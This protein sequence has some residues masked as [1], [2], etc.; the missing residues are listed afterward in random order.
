MDLSCRVEQLTLYARISP[1]K[2]TSV[3]RYAA[4]LPH[5]ELLLAARA[6]DASYRYL[7]WA[8][9]KSGDVDRAIRTGQEWIK[10][11]PQS[12]KAHLAMAQLLPSVRDQMESAL[13]HGER[14]L[15]LAGDEK[16]RYNI[17]MQIG[18]ILEK[19]R[20]HERAIALYEELGAKGH[21]ERVKVNAESVV[22]RVCKFRTEVS[23]EELKAE[24][25]AL[26]KQMRILM[27]QP[28]AAKGG[29]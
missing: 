17:T 27:S 9:F 24:K 2:E 1:N 7:V 5:A 18:Y 10:T 15:E 13:H 21:A 12:F 4:V 26:E 3:E 8:Q 25:E 6:D 29:G 23:S 11:F 22:R 20:R 28:E 14:A 16:D 19:L